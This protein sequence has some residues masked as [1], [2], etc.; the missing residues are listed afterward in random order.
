MTDLNE[1]DRV[2]LDK[3]GV[4]EYEGTVFAVRDDGDIWVK[5]D[6]GSR[7]LYHAYELKKQ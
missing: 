4:D 5:W 1:G 3:R 6:E 2:I 7:S